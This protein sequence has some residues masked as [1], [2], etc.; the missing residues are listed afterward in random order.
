M[1]F[2]AQPAAAFFLNAP[3][4]FQ[5]IKIDREAVSALART[6]NMLGNKRAREASL[7]TN[8]DDSTEQQSPKRQALHAPTPTTPTPPTPTPSE[9]PLPSSSPL[10]QLSASSDSSLSAD[11]LSAAELANLGWD[12]MP[13]FWLV[14]SVDA[15]PLPFA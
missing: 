2:S 3:R 1:L 15:P 9:W 7:S 10:S 8:D 5:P 13:T 4:F 12:D 14:D 6:I 11:D